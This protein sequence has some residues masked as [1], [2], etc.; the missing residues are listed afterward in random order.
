MKIE[1]AIEI[2]RPTEAV[3]AFV[4]DARNDPRWCPRVISCEQESGE[5]PGLG[6]RYRALEKPTFR[7]RQMR[8]IEVIDFA[9]PN[10]IVSTQQ[11]D[12]ADF[13]ITYLLEP[14]G[15]GTRLTQ[16]DELAW[17]LP[18]IYVPIASRIV[19]RNVRS[20]LSFLKRLLEADAA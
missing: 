15:G 8:W 17:R 19:P 16:R 6:A 3:F 10:R 20:Q 18:R 11:D 9:P 5:G 4:A 13:T 7:P 12:V 2:E 14:T 1:R